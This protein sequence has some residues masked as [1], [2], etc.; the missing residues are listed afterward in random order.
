[1]VTL[2]VIATLGHNSRFKNMG[3]ESQCLWCGRQYR[4]ISE[5]KNGGE[6]GA[7][8]KLACSKEWKRRQESEMG[9]AT[10]IH[11]SY[12]LGWQEYKMKN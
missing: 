5:L 6:D 9:K 3:L 10:L 1:M 7:V 8:G 2:S 11:N 12:G 4:P